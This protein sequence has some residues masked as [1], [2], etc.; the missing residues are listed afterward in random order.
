MTNSFYKKR[1]SNRI[2]SFSLFI[3]IVSGQLFAQNYNSE[4]IALAN[5]LTRMYM[6]A[7]YEGV[8]V[9]NDYDSNY[10]LSVVALDKSKYPNESTLFRVAS[11]KAMSQASRFFNG[12]TITDELIITTTEKTNGESRIETIEKINENSAGYVKQLQ[13]LT[14]FDYGDGLKV[15]I[16]HV[17]I[18]LNQ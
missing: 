4:N 10:L 16:F 7:P 2:L 18:N 14:S 15:F 3:F 11:V 1:A 17:P 8:R 13:L 5:F 12:S 9:V 6:N